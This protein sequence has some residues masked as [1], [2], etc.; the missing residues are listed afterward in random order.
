M[1]APRNAKLADQIKVVIAQALERRVKD[2]RLGFLTV[3]EVRLSG[4]NRE[5][6]VFYTVLG[7]D[8][9]RADT[10]EALESAR[11]LIRSQVGKQLGMKFTPTIAF[12]LDAVPET[13]AQIE[14]VLARVGAADEA[15]AEAGRWLR[16]RLG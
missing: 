11:G 15:V 2:P 13:A 14:D 1:A 7:D 8:R 3:T 6:T 5:A 16:E 9:A 4:D 12:V 10:A